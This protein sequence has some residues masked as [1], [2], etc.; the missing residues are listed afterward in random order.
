MRPNRDGQHLPE[1]K[2]TDYLRYRIVKA[3]TGLRLPFPGG[4]GGMGWGSWFAGS[5]GSK[6][7][8]ASEI[9][10][11]HNL[12]LVQAGV[13]W[14]ARGLNSARFQV[15]EVDPDS[16][17]K[18]IPDHPVA[19]LFHRPNPYYS[20]SALM[21]GIAMN[22]LS[23][24]TAYVLI[25][26]N[27]MGQPAQLWSEPWWSIRPRWP[28]N[29]SEVISYY[30][31]WRNGT[32][33]S[34]GKGQTL[35]NIEVLV[36]PDG[37]NPDTRRGWNSMTALLVEHYTD[38]RAGL[39][40]AQLMRSGLVPPL[41]VG[42]GTKDMPFM[43]PDGTLLQK[44]KGELVRKMSGDSAGEPM[45]T[46]GPSDVQKLGFDYSAV[47]LK[48]IRQIPV[49][50]FCAAMGISPIS[51]HLDAGDSTHANYNNVQGY[52]KHDYQSYIVG[53]QDVIAD[54]VDRMILPMFGEQ[55]NVKCAW[56]YTK[57]PLMQSDKMSE[58]KRTAILWTT[59]AIDRAEMREAN[60][61]NIRTEGPDKDVGV[62]Y[63]GKPQG[64]G[65]DRFGNDPANPMSDQE[66]KHWFDWVDANDLQDGADWWKRSAPK[67]ARGL[68]KAVSVKP[69]GRAGT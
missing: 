34:I 52:L 44:F 38:K 22:W 53:L 27:Q 12:G 26:K 32:W 47:G 39:F 43:D 41:I 64:L 31:I 35:S 57:T 66:M 17:E 11:V 55:R 30:E 4:S 9:G 10:P 16:K 13:N 18:D 60:S 59:Q 2:F 3:L 20:G 36:I 56:D 48:D 28:M 42:L 23:Y 15:V 5:S 37:W 65:G 50:R 7:D 63:A 14:V 6:I 58:T 62:Y 29:G 33:I 21:Q 67:E 40:M 1:L 19:Q 68:V 24:A 46:A 49:T 69:N 61:Y 51:L 45:V 8:F 25:V 54:E